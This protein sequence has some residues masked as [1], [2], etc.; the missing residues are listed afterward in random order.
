MTAERSAELLTTGWD[1]E[2]NTTTVAMGK[3]IRFGISMKTF[4]KK[5]GLKE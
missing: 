4:L 1:A 3:K 5:N 2:F